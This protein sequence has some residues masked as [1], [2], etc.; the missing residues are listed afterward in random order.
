MASNF[1]GRL[2]RY[3]IYAGVTFMLGENGRIVVVA[4]LGLAV[5]L[6]LYKLT[7]VVVRA[8]AKKPG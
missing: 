4:T 7:P 8:I 5:A 6:G 3:M 2:I 1:I